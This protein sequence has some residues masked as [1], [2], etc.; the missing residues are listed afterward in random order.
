MIDSVT[1]TIIFLILGVVLGVN[2]YLQNFLATYI[3]VKM[4]KQAGVMVGVVGRRGLYFKAG[5]LGEDDTV[6]YRVNRKTKATFKTE[7][8]SFWPA[9]GVQ[10]AFVKEGSDLALTADWKAVKGADPIAYDQNLQRAWN[11]PQIASAQD[12]LLFLAV[13]VTGVVVLFVA[14]KVM[15]IEGALQ[16]GEVVATVSGVTP[17]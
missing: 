1:T 14:W 5:K 11:R 13:V 7:N 9:I 17:Q 16:A 10:W 8:A 4:K 2:F 6:T 12:R 3:S 15:G